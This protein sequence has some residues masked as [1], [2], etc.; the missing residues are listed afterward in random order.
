MLSLNT[1]IGHDM[2]NLVE[3]V[4]K[5]V[6]AI[7]LDEQG[8][9]G[10]TLGMNVTRAEAA[11]IARAAITAVFDHLMEPSGAAKAAGAKSSG[12][13][14]DNAHEAYRATLAH[15]RK[16]AGLWVVGPFEIS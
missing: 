15:I 11:A 12:T 2:D 3:R 8:L 14:P 4:R 5:A 10:E 13:L 1:K 7:R 9:E 6:T 16:E